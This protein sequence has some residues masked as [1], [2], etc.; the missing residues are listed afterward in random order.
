M[1]NR[2]LQELLQG[3]PA[4]TEAMLLRELLTLLCLRL[5]LLNDRTSYAWCVTLHAPPTILL[6]QTLNSASS[7]QSNHSLD[8]ASSC[9]PSGAK[10]AKLLK[11]RPLCTL[12]ATTGVTSQRELLLIT[13]VGAQGNSQ[14]F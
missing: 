11:A 12:L 4:L 7:L 1:S 9:G 5:N 14:H 6:T 2:L 8:E 10:L 13:L 3:C